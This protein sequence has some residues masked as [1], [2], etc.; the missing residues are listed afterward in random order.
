MQALNHSSVASRWL[1]VVFALAIA[2]AYANSLHI[3]FYFDDWHAVAQNPHIRSLREIPRFFTD[4][5]TSSVL[6]ANKDMRPVLLTTLA[7]N[8]AVSRLE[9]WSYHVVNLVLHWCAVML[10]LRIVRDHLWLGAAAMPVAVGAALVVALHPLNTTP[11]NSTSARSALLTAVFYLGAFDAAVRGRRLVCL[12][13][14]ALALLTKGTASTLPLAIGA[15]WGVESVTRA[16]QERRPRSYVLLV[17]LCGL[18]VAAGIYR[19]ALVPPSALEGA[20]EP[21]ITPW[22]YCMTGWSAYLY[23]LRLFIWPN[24]LVIDRKDYHVVQNFLEPQA[25]LSL[26]AVAAFVVA[27]WSVRRRVPALTVAA[28]WYGITLATESTCFPLAEAVNEHRPYLAM[29][30]LGTAGGLLVWA[31]AGWLGRVAGRAREG[32]F[33]VLMAGLAVT[34]GMATHARNE[35]W[36]DDRT[37]W[38]DATEKAPG[39]A[40][41]WLNAGHAALQSNDL[42][43]ARR[44]LLEAHR[45]NPEY[46]FV[47]MNLVVLEQRS[48]DLPAALAWADDAVRMSPRLALTHYYR[49]LPLQVLGRLDEA[50]AA[51]QTAT[52]LDPQY[53][54]AWAAQGKLLEAR[55]RW[56]EAAAAYDHALETDPTRVEAA[57]QSALVYHYWLRDPAAGVER[58]RRVLA[59]NSTHYGAH[60]QLAMA[61]LASGRKDAAVAAWAEFLPMAQA[62]HD[63]ASIDS[64]PEALR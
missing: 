22:R 58:Y 12:L 14:A 47:Q 45:L 62:L 29:L 48:G 31:V 33:A 39:N 5:D 56:M 38:I 17:G 3:G 59:L 61:L 35:T 23:Y 51:L 9:P 42:P 21:E 36:R 55:R 43:A 16:P 28:L 57:M 25:W 54:D 10:V 34:L 7:L 24:A 63:Q 52:A 19:W 64:A 1:P 11:V 4:P 2:G 53:T 60:Y 50:L 41:A 49:A 37:L 46:A 32:C 20:H 6:P 30:G 44:E 8:Y 13:L 18:V 15:Y 26:G 27:A 40:R